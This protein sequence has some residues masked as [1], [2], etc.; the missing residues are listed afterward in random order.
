M[1]NACREF[2]FLAEF[3]MVQGPNAQDLF[4]QVLGKTL[5]LLTVS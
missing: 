5:V 1:E 3:F 2:I 4:G